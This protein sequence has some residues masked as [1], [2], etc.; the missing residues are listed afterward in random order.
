MNV[1]MNGKTDILVNNAG[2]FPFM[3]FFMSGEEP[4]P[5]LNLDD[6]LDWQDQDQK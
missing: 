3:P 2:I 1:E 4:P 6:K 5:A